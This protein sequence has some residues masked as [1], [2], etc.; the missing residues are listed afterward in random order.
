MTDDRIPCGRGEIRVLYLDNHLLAV[1][2]PPNVPVQR[3]ISGDL[4]VFTACKGYIKE[5]FQKPG[6]VYMGLVHRLDRP[7][8]G[9][10]L[11]ARTSKAAKRLSENFAGRDADK[12][13]LA[14]L[15]GRME[16]QLDMEDWLLKDS[17][18]GSSRAVPEGTPGAKYARLVSEP[19]A[20][21]QAENATL[22]LVTLYTGRSHQIRVQLAART[23]PLWVYTRY[24]G[25]EKGQQIALWAYRLTV[26]HPTL[27]EE[28]SFTSLPPMDGIWSAFDLEGLL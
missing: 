13:Y 3:D 1:E 25:A 8:G 6:E 17:A 9:V 21:C 19:V 7:V 27:R 22:A 26:P 5:K 18:T 20:Y 12:R 23:L 15:Q 10:L 16:A 4:D 2:K 11:L 24:G 28:I 14:V